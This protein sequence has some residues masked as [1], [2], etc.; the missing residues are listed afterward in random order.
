MVWRNA[1][2]IC[3]RK[4][5][6]RIKKETDQVGFKGTQTRPIVEVKQQVPQIL[7]SWKEML[8]KFHE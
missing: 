2:G 5:L 8:S 4:I 3:E 7:E 1:G 6:F